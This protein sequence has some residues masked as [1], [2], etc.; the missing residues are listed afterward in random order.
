M[1]IPG[2][3]H[4]DVPATYHSSDHGRRRGEFIPLGHQVDTSG[5]DRLLLDAEGRLRLLPFEVLREVNPL[6]LRIWCHRNALYQL[7]TQELIDYL[8]DEVIRGRRAIEICA[9]RC[10][11]GRFLGIPATD[12]YLSASNPSVNAYYK[13]N[14]Q[15]P[16]QPS[17][18]VEQLEAF[19]AVKKYRPEVVIGCWATHWSQS[20]VGSSWGVREEQILAQVATYCVVGNRAAHDSKPI[21]RQYHR[22]FSP[23]WLI[24]RSAT[25]QFN[26]IYLWEARPGQKTIL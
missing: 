13:A 23:P 17:P 22:V 11:V 12:S 25:P 2:A 18:H 7:P 19:Q 6:E 3:L 9:G 1:G 16:I 10:D 4:F 15:E 5:I 24:S 8:R 20:G 21:R 26:A 14:G